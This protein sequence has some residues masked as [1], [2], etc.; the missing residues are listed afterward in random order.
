MTAPNIPVRW[1]VRIV[2]AKRFLCKADLDE[3]TEI[4]SYNDPLYNDP[5][6]FL[7]KEAVEEAVKQYLD[8]FVRAKL[9]SPEVEIVAYDRWS[10]EL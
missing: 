10:R 9:S 5:L 2:K 8:D 6:N 1:Q 7:S 4:S 3:I